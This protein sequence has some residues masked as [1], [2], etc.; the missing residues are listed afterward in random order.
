MSSHSFPVD[1]DLTSDDWQQIEDLLD[2]LGVRARKGLP[3]GDFYRHLLERFAPALGASGGAVWTRGTGDSLRLESQ[4]NLGLGTAKSSR[5]VLAHHQAAVCQ[6]LESGQPRVTTLA[7]GPADA[8]RNLTAV[9]HPFAQGDRLAGVIELVWRTELPAASGRAYVRVLEAVAELTADYHRQSELAELRS[10]AERW[11]NYDQFA[12]RVHR[13]LEV[14][15][16]AYAVANEARRVIECDRVSVLLTR[17]R[18]V[19]V[20]AISGVDVVERR[21]KVV[22]ALETLAARAARCGEPIWYHDGI[23]DLPDEIATPLDAYL[24][25]SHARLLALVPLLEPLDE[26]NAS[27]TSTP[28]VIGI[29]VAEHFQALPVAEPL[30]QRVAAVAG[31]AALAL[32][33]SVQH[34]RMPLARAGR[35]LGKVR[36]LAEARQLPKTVLALA[37]LTAAAAALVL[38]PAAFEVEARGELQPLERRD[39]FASDDGVVSELLVESNGAVQAD[40][41]LVVLRKSELEL[42]SRRILGELQ[43]AEKKLASLRAE[44]LQDAPATGE[45]RRDPHELAAEEEELKATLAGLVGQQAILD[46]QQ[47]N[48]TIRSPIAGQAITWNLEQLLAARPV[49]R[50][51]ALLSVADLE[52]PWVLE[53]HVADDR[54]GHVLAARDAISP[55]LDVDF[56]LPSDPGRKYRGRVIEIAPSTEV[57]AKQESSVL[58]TVAFDKHSVPALRPGATVVARIHCGRRSLG[59]VWLHDL[60]DYVQSWWW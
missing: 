4:L 29:L 20:A 35:V 9:L 16:T 44:R 18:Q 19:R 55:E 56:V 48:L 21:S 42:E 37:L 40:Q 52:G 34:S 6:V 33:N 32:H 28:R 39:V 23:A 38:V 3:A 2:E 58:V 25:E 31:H 5:E 10:A 43:T 36:W 22:H 57:D 49:Q 15:T 60:Y 11:R 14:E 1:S 54:A 30:R 50:G 45:R 8:D 26:S 47:R 17:G 27:N 53:L 13:T 51:Q 41:P 59:Y 7:S 24:E 46:E 12:Q